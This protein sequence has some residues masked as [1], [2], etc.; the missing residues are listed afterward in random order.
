MCPEPFEDKTWGLNF[1]AT[2]SE[3]IELMSLCQCIIVVRN[4]YKII[5]VKIH[6]K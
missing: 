6:L 4:K 5:G 2:H 1:Y 3:Y